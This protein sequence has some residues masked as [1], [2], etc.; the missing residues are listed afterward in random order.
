MLALH[1][2]EGTEGGHVELWMQRESNTETS[3]KEV[4]LM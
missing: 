3:N 4:V 2:I 1:T